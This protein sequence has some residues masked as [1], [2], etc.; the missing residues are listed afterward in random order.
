[1]GRVST[2]KGEVGL[3]FYGIVSF[4]HLER[5]KDK[6]VQRAGGCHSALN[7]PP[8]VSPFFPS[9]PSFNYSFTKAVKIVA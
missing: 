4:W 5:E 8:S 1:M 3:A 6:L 9:L 2:Q 7:C